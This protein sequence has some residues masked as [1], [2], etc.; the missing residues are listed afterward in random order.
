MFR[1]ADHDDARTMLL[2]SQVF[3]LARISR[4]PTVAGQCRILAGF[5]WLNRSLSDGAVN[6]QLMP[7]AA[8]PGRCC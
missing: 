8:G 7:R 5:P 2:S 1:A 4:G 3:R 6:S